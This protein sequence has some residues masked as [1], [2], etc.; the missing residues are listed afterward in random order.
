MTNQIVDTEGRLLAAVDLGSNS[1]YMVIARVEHGEVRPLE[2]LGETVQLASGMVAGIISDD[3]IARGLQCLARF[4]QA[5]NVLQPDIV[6]MVGTNS[7]RVAKNSRDFRH[8]AEAI[9]GYPLEV[10]SG[11]EEARL[12]YLG[13]AHTLA[14]DGAR[15]VVDIGGG[16]TEFIIG[17]RFEA[18]LLESLH[19]GCVSYGERFFA[20]GNI[21]AAAF[22]N[23]YVSAYSEVLN[24]RSAFIRQGWDDVVGSSGTLRALE[25]VIAAQ[26]WAESG[27]SAE[28]LKKLRK[29]LF[30]Y[31]S[32]KDLCKLA[33][34][35]ERRRNVFAS[36]VA[37]SCAFF[38]ALEIKNMRISSGALREGIIYDTIGR[39]S[40][41]DVRERSVNALMQRY[42]IEEQ[43]VRK[44][45]ET[46]RYLFAA[47]QDQW[48]LCQQDLDLLVWACRLHEVGLAIAHSGFH[49]HGQYLMENSD[50]PGF[51]KAE[52]LELGLLVRGHR[53]KFPLDEIEARANGR[54]QQLERLCLLLRLSVLFKYVAAVEDTPAFQLS[55]A[56][57]EMRISYPCGWLLN[58]PLTRFA[59]EREQG[60]L[61]KKGISL[62]L[63]QGT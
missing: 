14:N 53:Q 41:E 7:L 61:A 31:P 42:N 62:H 38:D 18:R 37:I 15:L 21:T 29:L 11:R 20:G 54:S 32:V 23:A 48:Q 51:S 47:V 49:K 52:Q 22:E 2:R 17:E 44:V 46:A 55:V 36:G 10:V 33:G 45:E 50:L 57:R 43:Q 59:L 26:G 35:S 3:A 30:K 60:L 6:R 19:M 1:F 63:D 27:I 34:L 13:V 8:A 9:M 58:H 12:V 28:N 24:I 16:S 56:G 39:L 25:S 5:L 4:R 40:H